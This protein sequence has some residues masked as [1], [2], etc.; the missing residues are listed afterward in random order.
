[1]GDAT[2]MLE[3]FM[4]MQ[5][6]NSRFFYAIDLDDEKH[7]KNVFWVDAKGREDNQEFEDVI[8]FD[9]KYITNKYKMPFA[10]FIGV[11]N[12]FQSRL[13]GCALLADESSYK[14][15][16]SKHMTLVLSLTYT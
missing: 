8:S 12:H 4:A 3:C 2:A 15:G 5:E 16:I 1:L 6:E 10:L 9:T 11:D 14:R 13:L 7:V